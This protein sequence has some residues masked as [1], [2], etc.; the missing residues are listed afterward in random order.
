MLLSKKHC[1]SKVEVT[2]FH[3]PKVNLL[4]FIGV[5]ASCEIYVVY[6]ARHILL[7]VNRNAQ[8]WQ[9]SWSYRLRDSASDW[10]RVHAT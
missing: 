7:V 1:T 10:G 6:V 5:G 2:L 3:F 4:L 8:S 9:K